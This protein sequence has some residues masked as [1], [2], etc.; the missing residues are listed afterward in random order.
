LAE[1]IKDIKASLSKVTQEL[2]ELKTAINLTDQEISLIEIQKAW[3]SILSAANHMRSYAGT[4]S[5]DKTKIQTFVDHATVSSTD[6]W[7]TGIV[8]TP[9][10]AE[11]FSGGKDSSG[12][13]LPERIDQRY[14]ALAQICLG[15]KGDN[16]SRNYVEWARGVN[17]FID[18]VTLYGKQL[19]EVA[20]RRN[21]EQL[22]EAGRGIRR[23]IAALC[24]QGTI[25]DRVQKLK[26]AFGVPRSG[27]ANSVSDFGTNTY[28]SKLY[29][30]LAPIETKYKSASAYQIKFQGQRRAMND[31]P[32]CLYEFWNDGYRPARMPSGVPSDAIAY[33]GG[34]GIQGCPPMFFISSDPIEA[35]IK[36]NYLTRTPLPPIKVAVM[37]SA[38]PHS[39]AY[40]FV[41]V[42]G[43][44]PSWS[45]PHDLI[46]PYTLSYLGRKTGTALID[47]A[48]RSMYDIQWVADTHMTG[49]LIPFTGPFRWIVDGPLDPAKAVKDQLNAN[50][51]PVLD[52]ARDLL[53]TERDSPNFRSE[54]ATA[55]EVIDT[56]GAL[57]PELRVL[58]ALVTLA[59]SLLA[60]PAGTDGSPDKQKWFDGD[61]LPVRPWLGE[62]GV[63][64]TEAAIKSATAQ[65]ITQYPDATSVLANGA[66]TLALC[67]KVTMAF[68]KQLDTA[69]VQIK[70]A[71][72][73]KNSVY[74]RAVMNLA[75][76][77]TIYNVKLTPMQT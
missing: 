28:L 3:D 61:D 14:G 33:Y 41:P 46:T 10:T 19:D 24:D 73:A 23:T 52:A 67:N 9:M 68:S 30:A 37:I 53:W 18:A 42:P 71:K 40:G 2:N 55:V 77:A 11:I 58:D 65:I 63:A 44:P 21:I 54:A 15:A 49:N 57:E 27:V 16:R 17:S 47:G 38:H 34:A 48:S 60:A 56:N 20:V 25:D 5:F 64:T 74:E 32:G 62:S 59:N 22:W 69:G 76:L 29:A 13:R 12:R 7:F 75:T 66:L 8:T 31:V 6:F 45:G 70:N 35:A 43:N 50:P 39:R 36:Q 26:Q 72:G 4:A 51:V 1:D